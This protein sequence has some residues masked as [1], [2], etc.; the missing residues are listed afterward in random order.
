MH[1]QQLMG[2]VGRSHLVSS[3][4]APA[5]WSGQA[6]CQFLERQADASSGCFNSH[7]Y[8]SNL[9]HCKSTRM[10]LLSRFWLLHPCCS[11]YRITMYLSEQQHGGGRRSETL[12]VNQRAQ[13]QAVV[14]FLSETLKPKP[15]REI[16][17]A[18]WFQNEIP[19]VSVD[20]ISLWNDNF[21]SSCVLWVT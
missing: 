9:I 5:M 10:P 19:R 20:K 11:F 17:L 12:L 2:T 6:W 8:I 7:F 16:S 21:C 18:D 4:S 3:D 14:R 1:T 13:A 15:L